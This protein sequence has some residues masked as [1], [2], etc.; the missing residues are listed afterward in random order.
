MRA[1]PEPVLPWMSVDGTGDKFKG[2][3]EAEGNGEAVLVPVLAEVAE[4]VE[5]DMLREVHNGARGEK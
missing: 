5:E 3:R 2:G 4:V 1:V